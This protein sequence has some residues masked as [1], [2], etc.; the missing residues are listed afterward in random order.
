MVPQFQFSLRDL[1]DLCVSCGETLENS[2]TAETQRARGWRREP[3]EALPTNLS[4]LL[5]ALF[6]AK[7][8]PHL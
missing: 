6:F 5:A 3:Q 4:R 2:I 1:C 7:M 8:H